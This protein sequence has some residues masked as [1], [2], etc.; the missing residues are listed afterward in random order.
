MDRRSLILGFLAGGWIATLALVFAPGFGLSAARADGPT[1][2]P[3]PFG[4]NGPNNAGPTVNPLGGP[5]DPKGFPSPG[6][7]TA[8]SNRTA[9]A[10]S[11]SVGNGESVVY[12]F[13]TESKRLLVYQYR[14]LIGH[15]RP[16]AAGDSGG[17]RLLAARHMDYDLKLESY[18]DLSERTRS[19]LKD[20]FES[21]LGPT[22]ASAASDGIPSKRVDVPGGFR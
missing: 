4:P 3:Q 14:G 11:A 15:N 5:P 9:I 8:D 21:A 16:L 10:L 19:E 6:G 12:F 2:G 18:R 20:D 7:G 13:D 22:E 1:P 17:L